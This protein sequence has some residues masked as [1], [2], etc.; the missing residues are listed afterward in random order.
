MIVTQTTLWR[1][2]NMTNVIRTEN[3]S[4]KYY[5]LPL[6]KKEF[7]KEWVENDNYDNLTNVNN[8]IT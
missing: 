3:Q 1:H 6:K 5:Q 4:K 2:H 7:N 8:V